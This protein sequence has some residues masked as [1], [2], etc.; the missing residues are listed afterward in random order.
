MQLRVMTEPQEGATYDDLLRVAQESERLGFDAFFR[1]DHI[2]RIGDDDTTWVGSTDAWA[3]LAGLARD[4]ERIRLGTM[5][6]ASTFRLPGMLAVA[7]ATVDAMSGGRVELGLG[8]AWFDEEHAAYGIPF[9]S[10]RERFDRLDE[11]LS[12]V[13]GMWETEPGST[14]S[15]E[16]EHYRLDECPAMP[17]PVQRPRV[18]VIVGGK[19]PTR[20]PAMA[21][22][23]ADEFNM[24]FERPDVIAAQFDRVRGAC[25][26]VGRDPASLRLS[27]AQTLCVGETEDDVA[28][29]AA[30]IGQDV[31]GLR[32][33]GLAG[34]PA[35]V[36][37]KAAR[38]GDLGATR[39][40][41]QV[42]DLTDLDHLALVA[43]EVMPHLKT[44]EQP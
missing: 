14:Y 37:D 38:L 24:P 17:K 26:G 28:R 32:A 41:L 5:L 8:A 18:P 40:Y 36:L 39:L 33:K 10:V 44:E 3:T 35:E 23:H 25:E 9:P 19:G 16:G 20:T 2:L 13:T 12:I 31:S 11:Q 7:V 6:T 22:R 4:T 42:M 21:A 34:T 30:A 1:S 29:R 15:F 27:A 43:A